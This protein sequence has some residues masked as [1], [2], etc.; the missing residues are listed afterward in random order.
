MFR[1]AMEVTEQCRRLTCAS[2]DCTF[3]HESYKHRDEQHAHRIY[4]GQVPVP[5][6][7]SVIIWSLK[8]L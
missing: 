4:H 5:G 2:V 7:Y 8:R 3:R 6:E 1:A